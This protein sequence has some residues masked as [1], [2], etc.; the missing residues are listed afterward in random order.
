MT[1]MLALC[2]GLLATGLTSACS[3][4]SATPS[5]APAAAAGTQAVTAAVDAEA[6]TLFAQ[7]CAM[8]HGT[9]G[10]GD[11]VAAANLNP[12]PRNYTDAAWQASVTDDYLAKVIVEGGGAVGKSMLMPGNPDLKD[13][14]QLVAGIVKVIRAFSGR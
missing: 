7:R 1:R 8:C 12:K 3:D 10:L 5:Q 11:G 14:P 9:S 6:A 2:F 4:D 13:K